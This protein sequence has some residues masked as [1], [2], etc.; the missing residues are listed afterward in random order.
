[1]IL[2][3][4]AALLEWLRRVLLLFWIR[5]YAATAKSADNINRHYRI[6][7]RYQHP[8]NDNPSTEY[9]C[10]YLRKSIDIPLGGGI[11]KDARSE[12]CAHKESPNRR[13]WHKHVRTIHKRADG[14]F[15][16]V[17]E[18]FDKR[19]RLHSLGEPAI[20]VQNTANY[21]KTFSFYENGKQHCTDG[22]AE[23]VY[24]TNGNIQETYML[25]GKR[26]RVDGPAVCEWDTDAK[27][28]PGTE[29]YFFY[30]AFLNSAVELAK[31]VKKSA[32]QPQTTPRQRNRSKALVSNDAL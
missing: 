12:I 8:P 29:K 6:L 28:V 21:C 26:H 3:G 1:M 16:I 32:T 30:G 22:P 31:R 27:I 25:N 23:I 14:G 24:L 20:V 4:F 5:L 7:V 2:W 11:M 10:F 13:G 15:D 17:D 9:L 19:G 18:Y